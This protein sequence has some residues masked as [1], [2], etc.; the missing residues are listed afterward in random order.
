MRNNITDC[1]FVTIYVGIAMS[2]IFTMRSICTHH[3]ISEVNDF[4]TQQEIG[5][6]AWII[7]RGIIMAILV[8]RD[9]E[10]HHYKLWV[11]TRIAQALL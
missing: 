11:V 6:A 5:V 1:V 10:F 2:C 4:N 3:N 8:H 9:K 7:A